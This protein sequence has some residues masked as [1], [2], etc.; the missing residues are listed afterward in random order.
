[1]LDN[2]L[3]VMSLLKEAKEIWTRKKIQKMIYLL[4]QRG[5]PFNEHFI[6]HYYGP[7]SAELQVELDQLHEAGL[8]G[9]EHKG[10][11]YYFQLKPKG[12][13]ILQKKRGAGKRIES[14]YSSLIKDLNSLAPQ[15]LEMMAT[16]VYLEK[17]YGK[18]E[19]K[20]RSVLKNIKPRIVGVF[21]QAWAQLN[22]LGLHTR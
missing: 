5:A 19:R 6:F 18:S 3:M 4:Q 8:I 14:M 20:L 13:I 17:S 22:K 9:Q 12:E 21:D 1:M 15:V 10:D 11:S 2:Y 16:I 7:Y